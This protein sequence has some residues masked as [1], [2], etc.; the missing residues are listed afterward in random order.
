MQMIKVHWDRITGYL[1]DSLI[2]VV[3]SR[4]WKISWYKY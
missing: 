1:D 3:C 4:S 2:L